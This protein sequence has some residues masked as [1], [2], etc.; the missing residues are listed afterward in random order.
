MLARTVLVVDDD[1]DT[2][3]PLAD[4]LTLHDYAV[5]TA[6]DPVKAIEICSTRPVDILLTDIVIPKITGVQ[7]AD[8]LR[9]IRPALK[10]VYMSAYRCK[11]APLK[12]AP[13]LEK[14]FTAE[15]ML[16]TIRSV[17]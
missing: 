1:V 13:V 8:W 10:V 4:I 3:S 17:F 11:I 6:H 15:S 9:S 12:N 7:L 14:P 16:R 5:V 2:A